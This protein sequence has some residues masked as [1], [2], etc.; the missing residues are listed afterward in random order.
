[1]FFALTPFTIRTSHIGECMLKKSLLAA[2]VAVLMSA[3]GAEAGVIFADNFNAETQALNYNAFANW[4]V[5]AGS[6]DLIGTGFFDFYPGH[7]NYVDMDG[8]TPNRNPAGQLTSKTSFAAG[9]YSLSFLLGG[10]ARGDTNTVEVQF[11]TFI[12]DFTL[13]SGDPLALHTIN[14]FTTGGNLSYTNLGAADNVGLI[15]DDVSLSTATAV[16]E[17]MTLSIVSAGV[18][19]AIAMRRRKK[20]KQA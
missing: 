15:L 20:A 16:P 11:G 18:A 13:L 10:S 1:M 4:N 9:T 7:G 6:V 2:T 8:T 19:G 14:F 12:Q 5:S 3:G 17:P